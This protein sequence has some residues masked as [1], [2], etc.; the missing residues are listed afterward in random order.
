[1]KK[2]F[3]L[4]LALSLVL[5]LAA[6]GGDKP[7]GDHVSIPPPKSS[8]NG[9]GS[10]DDKPDGDRVSIPPSESS[11]DS[12]GSGGAQAEKFENQIALSINKT[13]YAQGEHI[14]VTVDFS[15]FDQSSA[16]I[17][18]VNSETAHG[19][20]TP[21]Q[22]ACEE[23]R[24]LSDFSELPFLLWAPEKDGLFDVR[25]YTKSEDGE[26]LASVSFGVGSAVLPTESTPPGP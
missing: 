13:N 4:L 6:C 17:V 8:Q 20:T 15:E 14:E 1:M 5:A 23:I 3:A 10:G 9:E 18:M 24:W 25:V 2:L 16:V 12:E 22:D 26:E 7:S 21:A 11:Q 19:K